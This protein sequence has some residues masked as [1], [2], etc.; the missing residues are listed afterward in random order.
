MGA[1]VFR[2]A[3]YQSASACVSVAAHSSPGLGGTCAW[4]RTRRHIITKDYNE[5]NDPEPPR[6]TARGRARAPAPARAYGA[7]IHIRSSSRWRF[8]VRAQSLGW[9]TAELH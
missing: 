9:Q 1:A 2:I 5:G 8:T 4:V 7:G 6:P 3:A